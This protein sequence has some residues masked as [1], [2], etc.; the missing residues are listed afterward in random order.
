MKVNMMVKNRG[1]KKL[2]YMRFQYF[3]KMENGS[4]QGNHSAEKGAVYGLQERI[5]LFYFVLL[6]RIPEAVNSGLADLIRS[7][8]NGDS[9]KVGIQ[10]N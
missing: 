3:L 2:M 4:R 10:N 8:K 1:G 7:I 6:I 5:V 9:L